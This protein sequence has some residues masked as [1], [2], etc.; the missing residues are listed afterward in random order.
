MKSSRE[1]VGMKSSTSRGVIATATFCV[2]AACF[3]ETVLFDFESE[4]DAAVVAAANP[5]GCSLTVTNGLATSGDKALRIDFPRSQGWWPSFTLKPP[6]AD[7][8]GYDRLVIDYTSLGESGDSFSLKIAGPDGPVNRR[9]LATGRQVST[10]GYEQWVVPL[11]WSPKAPSNNIARVHFNTYSPQGFSVVIDRLALLKSG[12]EPK[13]PQASFFM[14]E[15]LPLVVADAQAA[16]RRTDEALHDVDYERFRAACYRDGVRTPGMLLGKATSMEKILPRGRFVA[17]PMGADGLNVRLAG[18]EYE[19]VQLLVAADGRDLAGLRLYIEGDLSDESGETFSASNV[20]CHVMGYV[21]TEAPTCP[22]PVVRRRKGG[23]GYVREVRPAHVG[24]W[25]DPILGFLNGIDVRGH[26]IQSFWVRVRCPENQKPGTFGGT[27]V[28]A[29]TGAEAVRIPFKVRVNGFS[30]GRTPALPVI[31]SCGSPHPW[32]KA[33]DDASREEANAIR[34]DPLAPCN[35]YKRHLEEWVDFF[36]DYGITHDHLYKWSINADAERAIRRLKAQGRLGLVNLGFWNPPKEGEG[37]EAWRARTLPALKASY[38]KAKSLGILDHAHVYGADEVPKKRLADVRAAVLEIKKALPGVPVST[39]AVD[40]DY[41]VGTQLDV[42]DW[43][44][45]LTNDYDPKK[46]KASRSLGHQVWWYVCCG[47]YPPYANMFIECSAIEGR[48]LTG[49]Q[50]VKYRPDGFLYYQTVVWNARRCIETGPF[51]DWNPRSYQKTNGD[52]SWVCAGP[53]GT[54]VP[55]IRL[56]NF[57]DGLEDYAYA[58]LLEERLCQ[59]KSGKLK[60]KNELEWSKKA[61]ELL[62]VPREVVD[63]VK[64][65][66]EDPAAM[67]RWRDAMADLID[68]AE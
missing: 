35:L 33:R 5:G 55:T 57:R 42:M 67:Y 36:A 28:L 3:A 11:K 30:L 15:L 8:S 65:Y 45:P 60:V 19:S 66:T 63:T 12:E 16:G 13:P 38:K 24:W 44:C 68:E 43:F 34:N 49:A 62:S 59:V 25:P 46:A 40:L 4:S 51:T 9:C 2:A 27:L 64:N 41:G 39:T 20:D 29:A 7:W 50:A 21:K 61:E 1:I 54:P 58:R 53:D 37:L 10:K 23:A 18:N 48:M 22:S 31:V 6:V 17:Q 26:D 52:G 14:H 47:P 56:E 32:A